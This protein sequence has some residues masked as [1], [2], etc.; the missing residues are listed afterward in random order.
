LVKELCV[1]VFYVSE[2]E[3]SAAEH[4]NV[5]VP[6]SVSVAHRLSLNMLGQGLIN[7]NYFPVGGSLQKKMASYFDLDTRKWST[8]FLDA[9]DSQG[10]IVDSGMAANLLN[11][12]L[13][14][15]KMSN[16]YFANHFDKASSSWGD[17]ELI[18]ND[19]KKTIFSSIQLATN[20]IGDGLILWFQDEITETGVWVRRF[21][22]LAKEWSVAEKIDVINKRVGAITE[23]AVKLDRN[24]HGLAVWRQTDYINM[25]DTD[26]HIWGM[27]IDA[28][29]SSLST[30]EIIEIPQLYFSIDLRFAMNVRGDGIAVWRQRSSASIDIWANRFDPNTKSWRVAELI[31]TTDQGTAR[32]PVVAINIMKRGIVVW[33]QDG[34]TGKDLLWSN[35]LE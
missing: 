33:H 17:P 13:T 20:G 23:L 15:W 34:D 11:H 12:S 26:D 24:G 32:K 9:P 16:S 4:L 27:H 35:R 8:S 19:D 2:G 14:F 6:N 29:D 18:V 30:A 22:H 10:G 1:K 3:W 7:W 31:E 25:S 28:E 5:D 21:D